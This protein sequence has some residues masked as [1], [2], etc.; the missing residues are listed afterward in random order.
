MKGGKRM[1]SSHAN[2]VLPKIQVSSVKL[3]FFLFQD[4]VFNMRQ[5][6]KW[7]ILRRHHLSSRGI[8]HR[9]KDFLCKQKQKTTEGI[10]AFEISLVGY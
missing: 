10:H 6:I 1:A 5:T 9:R 7:R 3:C 8:K 4:F 2:P